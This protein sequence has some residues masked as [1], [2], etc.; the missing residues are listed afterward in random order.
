MRCEKE[1]GELFDVEKI[2]EGL[3]L[4][5]FSFY[6]EDESPVRVC[7]EWR[8]RGMIFGRG[9]VKGEEEGEKMKMIS[10]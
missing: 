1:V 3:Y 4:E 10:L 7:H 5:M 2:E 9:M 8:Q 6:W